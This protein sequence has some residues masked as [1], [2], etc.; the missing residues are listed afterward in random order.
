M[1]LSRRELLGIGALS[2]AAFFLPVQPL[3][4]EA[5]RN[6]LPTSQLPKPFQSPLTVPPVLAP[7]RTDAT[8]DYYQIT[9]QSADVQIVP[10]L[11]KTTIFGYNGITPGPTIVV[12]RGPAVN[13][14]PPARDVVVRQ[15]NALPPQHPTLRYTPTTSVHLHGNASQPQF[16]GWAEDLTAPGFFKDYLYPN[17]QDGR[18]LWYHDHAVGHTAENT[19]MGLAGVYLTDDGL[20]LPLPTGKYDIP[21]SSRTRSST[22][23]ANCCSS[24]TARRP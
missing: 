1:H 10:G 22:R 11:P 24:T 15:I 20:N 8:T 18:M 21:W 3:F 5:V 6:R 7:V 23:P 9:M 12:N 2:S 16:D 19:Y 13:G 17:D 4:A 14:R